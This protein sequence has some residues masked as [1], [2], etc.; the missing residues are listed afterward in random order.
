MASETTQ[1]IMSLIDSKQ[2][3]ELESLD[4]M[5]GK[6]SVLIDDGTVTYRIS[7]DALLGYFVN[8][9]V[10]NTDEEIDVTAL[11]AASCI[12]IIKAGQDV[13]VNQR[14]KGHFYLKLSESN[15]SSLY[16]AILEDN[17]ANSYFLKT[18]KNNVSGI[19][20]PDHFYNNDQQY[21]YLKIC[22]FELDSNVSKIFISETFTLQLVNKVTDG[23]MYTKNN[24]V[25]LEVLINNGTV[26]DD[27]IILTAEDH[28]NSTQVKKSIIDLYFVKGSSK[29]ELWVNIQNVNTVLL[30]RDFSLSNDKY[31]ETINHITSGYKA[32]Y[33]DNNTVTSKHVNNIY[34]NIGAVKKQ[35]V[36]SNY[37]LDNRVTAIEKTI[38]KADLDFKY[39]VITFN[40]NSPSNIN[41]NQLNALLIRTVDTTNP[42]FL[43]K[44]DDGTVKVSED[45]YYCISLKQG[46]NVLLNVT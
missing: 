18:S 22:E 23:F 6:E 46:Y 37:D 5:S 35:S 21:K 45:G 3:H 43:I 16:E 17:S 11:N 12:H 27:S 30:S 9:F 26:V 19:L 25:H 29:Y 10:G 32:I 42:L 31:P 44:N 33:T 36:T 2:I 34:E 15:L 28:S 41:E 40:S 4:S 13:P 39:N 14:V 7:I 8:R 1:D 38:L 24:K 20:F